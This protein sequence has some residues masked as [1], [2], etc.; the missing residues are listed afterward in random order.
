[1]IKKIKK[2]AVLGSGVMGSGIAC[3]LANA[4]ME[5]MMLDIVPFDL[6][7]DEKQNLAAKNKIVNEALSKA[8]KS[9]PAPLFKK[10]YAKRI[11]TGNFDDDLHKI[12]EYEW[13]IEVIIE[14]P[15]IKK[16]LF[17]KVEKY[18]TPGTFITT[19]TSGIPIKILT[20]GRSDDFKKYFMGTHFFNPP[21]YLPLLELIPGKD[22]SPEVIEFFKE[23][24]D[25]YFGKQGVLCKDTPG[26]I[27]N[28]VGLFSMANLMELTQKYNF[29][30][31]EVDAL[32]GDIIGRPKTGTYRLL[33]LVGIDVAD[34]V[35]KGLIQNAPNDEY[36]K[37][38]AGK[39][40]PEFMNYLLKNKYL[41]NKTGQGFYK[42][43]KEK[44]KNGKTI[45]HSLDIEK[46]EYRLKKKAFF[47]LVKQNKKIDNLKHKIINI[48][49]SEENE[50]NFLKEYFAG[51][52]SYA[53]NRIPEISDNI[54]SI[55]DGMKAGYAWDAGPFEYWDMIGLKKGIEEA[56]KLGYKIADWVKTMAKNGQNSFYLSK[57]KSKFSQ[58]I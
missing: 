6:N 58:S 47:N 34:K 26:F 15:K 28:R 50:A 2:V 46:N 24:G 41:G 45:I 17:E 39:D 12:K 52:F 33:D 57:N 20:E 56:E 14:N 40:N 53:S 21:R 49:E 35:L 7:D 29:T 10:E 23:F 31:E 51:L 22:T 42:K 36:L 27:A 19:N 4:G 16:E 44:D 32:T 30:I 5:V 54:Y 37:T 3:H 38:W 55:D 1:M 43:T 25:K 13:V 9:K 11:T 8:I 48:F 18:R